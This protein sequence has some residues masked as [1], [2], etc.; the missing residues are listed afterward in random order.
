[1][2]NEVIELVNHKEQGILSNRDAYN[3]LA[4]AEWMLINNEKMMIEDPED[5][6]NPIPNW[7]NRYW[8]ALAETREALGIP[9]HTS[10]RELIQGNYTEIARC[11]ESKAYNARQLEERVFDPDALGV[12]DSYESQMVEFAT[13]SAAHFVVEPPKKDKANENTAEREEDYIRKR[14]PVESENEREKMKNAPKIFSNMIVDEKTNELTFDAQK[15][16][17]R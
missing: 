12:Y 7:G 8:K 3:K 2:L 6:I 14:E 9:K 13:Q 5:P 16:D 1:M 15:E 10:M 11:I 17:F 4:A